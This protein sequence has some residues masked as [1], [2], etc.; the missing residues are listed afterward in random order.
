MSND[1]ATFTVSDNLA[2]TIIPDKDE[3]AKIIT[4]LMNDNGF[5]VKCRWQP[6]GKHVE[7][8]VFIWEMQDEKFKRLAYCNK[9]LKDACTCNGGFLTM[10][11]SPNG[12]FT[13]GCKY[14][15]QFYVPYFTDRSI[16][17]AVGDLN[18]DDKSIADFGKLAPAFKCMRIETLGDLK[19]AL[20]KWKGASTLIDRLSDVLKIDDYVN[21]LKTMRQAEEEAWKRYEELNAGILNFCNAEVKKLQKI[22][23]IELEKLEGV[24]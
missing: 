18:N 10:L 1:R 21:K 15:I 12:L 17:V 16:S 8:G 9:I 5:T 13:K 22:A 3:L 2:L 19:R 4:D 6:D 14:C 11:Y 20:G 23:V 7:S 24:K